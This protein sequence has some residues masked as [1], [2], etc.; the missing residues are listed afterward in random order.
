[1]RDIPWYLWLKKMIMGFKI[2]DVYN[3]QHVT[4]KGQLSCTSNRD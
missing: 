4:K 1:M 2:G 3:I